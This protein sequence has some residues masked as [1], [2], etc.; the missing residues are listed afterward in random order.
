MEILLLLFQVFIAYSNSID[1]QQ[2]PTDNSLKNLRPSTNED[3]FYF[4]IDGYYKRLYLFLLDNGYSIN[5]I[6]Y[7][8]T[9]VYPSQSSIKNCSFNQLSSVFN[10]SQIKSSGKSYYYSIPILSK[11]SFSIIRYSGSN[12]YG[13]FKASG[14]YT[15]FIQVITLDASYNTDITTLEDRNNYFSSYNEFYSSDYLYLYIKDKSK[16][17]ANPIYYCITSCLPQSYLVCNFSS[18]YYDEKNPTS[19]YD[20]LYS[21]YFSKRRGFNIVL[22][23]SVSSSNGLLSVK[24]RSSKFLSTVAI[25][26]IVIGPLAFIGIIIGLIV[27]CCKRR[28]S[29]NLSY[30]LT[31]PEVIASAPVYPSMD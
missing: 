5:K 29:R 30:V 17:L 22:K 4:S 14:S 24:V 3:Y 6:Y 26:F 16:L 15:H 13:T 20:Y 7:C 8:N 19:D 11:G 2:V 31:Q 28:A 25:V 1:I 23:F 10:D 21:F 18:L 12:S 9:Y 27:Y